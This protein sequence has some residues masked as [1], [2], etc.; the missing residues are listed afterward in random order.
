MSDALKRRAVATRLG[1]LALLCLHTAAA[2]AMLVQT[3]A[4]DPMLK[5]PAPLPEGAAFQ[6]GP[7]SQLFRVV[8]A[9]DSKTVATLSSNG[10]VTFWDPAS[11]KQ[12]SAFSA[13]EGDCFG[14]DYARDGKSLFVGGGDHSLVQ[15]DVATGKKIRDFQG[16]EGDVKALA[17]SP[18]GVRLASADNVGAI[19]VWDIASG[20]VLRTMTGHGDNLPAG[21]ETPTI[22]SLAWSPNGRVIVTEANDE[23]ARLWDAIGGKQLRIL[24]QH[25]GSVASVAISPNNVVGASTRGRLTSGSSHIRIWEVATGKIR[26]VI[27]GHQDDITCIA[28]SPDGQMIY[29]GA[30]DRTVR[31]W[32]VESGVEIRRYTLSSMPISIACSPDGQFLSVLAPREGLTSFN[33]TQAPVGQPQEACKDADEAWQKLNAPEYD[34]RANAFKY[35]LTALPARQGVEELLRRAHAGTRSVGNGGGGGGGGDKAQQRELITR[36]DDD[37]YSVR[38]SAF[39]ELR[40]LGGAVRSELA[41][42]VGSASPEVRTRAAELLSAIGGPYD[43][44]EVLVTELLRAIN[45]P[46]ARAALAKR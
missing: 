24:P 17:T 39:D 16:E 43:A 8:V 28:F 26:R 23:T 15:W 41:E 5:R 36:L 20:E 21:M 12:V 14:I 25:D 3:D 19:K 30:R 13:R 7:D 35:F 44:R 38:I 10:R 22:D 11:G 27:N 37:N 33:L 42:A 2:Q 32:D 1:M 40:E 18:D 31:Q 4:E 34:V 46:E 9:P 6:T 29:S 45:T